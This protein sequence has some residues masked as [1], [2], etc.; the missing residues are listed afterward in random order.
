MPEHRIVCLPFTVGTRNHIYLKQIVVSEVF[1][2]NLSQ[3]F[4]IIAV[5]YI[6][7]CHCRNFTIRWHAVR[8]EEIECRGAHRYADINIVE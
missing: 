4:Q 7:C 8:S 1:L 5:D 6:T 3:L 2:N